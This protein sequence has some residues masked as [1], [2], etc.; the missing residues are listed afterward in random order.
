[1]EWCDNAI[2]YQ[3]YIFYQSRKDVDSIFHLL[4]ALLL[5]KG[6]WYLCTVK[7]IEGY[8]FYD[9]YH[10]VGWILYYYLMHR[11]CLSMSMPTVKIIWHCSVSFWMKLY[12]FM[13]LT[14]MWLTVKAFRLKLYDISLY[15]YAIHTMEELKLTGNH[16][17]GSLPILTFSSDFD[18]QPH[19]QMLKEI[20]TQV[21]YH[22]HHL[23]ALMLCC[24]GIEMQIC[25]PHILEVRKFKTSF[26]KFVK[27]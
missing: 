5:C 6:H 4:S 12:M 19:W 23:N 14:L 26:F 21:G 17:K 2:A 25:H 7:I 15:L 9:L 27:H 3:F 20:M 1:M 22:I 24:Y 16:L 18:L 13:K 10:I 11:C 8:H